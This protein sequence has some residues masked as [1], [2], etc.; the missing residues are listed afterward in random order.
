MMLSTHVWCF[1]LL[2][3]NM[4]SS[5]HCIYQNIQNQLGKN[6][7][8]SAPTGSGKTILFELAIVELL[9]SLEQQNIPEHKVKIVYGKCLFTVVEENNNKE[10]ILN[11]TST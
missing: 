10:H 4:Q 2:Y 8:V 3:K 1:I 5:I 11:V 9:I 7:V 6:L